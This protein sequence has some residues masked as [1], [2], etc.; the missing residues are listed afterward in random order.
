MEVREEWEGSG[1]GGRKGVERSRGLWLS[2]SLYNV[3]GIRESLPM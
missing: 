2:S 1:V 3:V